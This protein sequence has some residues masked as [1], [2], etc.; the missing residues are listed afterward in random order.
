VLDPDEDHYV[1][2][3]Y[4]SALLPAI[5]LWEHRRAV[6]R[7]REQGRREVDEEAIFRAVGEMRAVAEK[8]VAT[9][10]AA[11]RSVARRAHLP[12]APEQRPLSSPASET[13]TAGA[14]KPFEEIE[15][16]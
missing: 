10:K 13:K 14:I 11:R 8:A 1:E 3:P 2:I 5:T 6:E 9:T 16:W 4:R 15:L 12:A 7:V